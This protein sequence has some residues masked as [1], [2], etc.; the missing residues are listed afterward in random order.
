MNLSVFGLSQEEYPPP[1]TPS[2]IDQS[3]WGGP[4]TR[5]RMSRKLEVVVAGDG[6]EW[7]RASVLR[8]SG[9]WRASLDVGC[10]LTEV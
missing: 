3:V 5:E 6:A 1:L 2:R 10:A 9:S 7:C 8:R 4:T